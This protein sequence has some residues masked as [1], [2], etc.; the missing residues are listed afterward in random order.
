MLSL[1]SLQTQHN[2][3]WRLSS[4]KCESENGLYHVSLNYFLLKDPSNQKI[5]QSLV[6]IEYRIVM[7]YNSK[8]DSIC[9]RRS[10]H[11]CWSQKAIL[12]DSTKTIP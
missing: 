2:G 11:I 8:G 6:T 5:K 4:L 12:K 7:T 9:K 10:G 1:L 3:S